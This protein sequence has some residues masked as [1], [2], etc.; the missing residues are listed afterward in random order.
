MATL[1]NIYVIGAQSTGKTTLVNA[2]ATHFEQH[3]E[4]IRNT[5]SQPKLI[6]EVARGVLQRHSY[7]ADDIVSSKSRALELQRLILEAQCEAEKA[8][9]KQWYISDRS[10][11]DP[12]VYARL[13]VG[14][15]ETS[16]LIQEPSWQYL[17]EMMRSGLVI[18]C[19]SGGEWLINDGVRLMPQDRDAWLQMHTTFCE[20]LDGF[21][22]QYHVLPAALRDLNGRVEFALTRWRRSHWHIRLLRSKLEGSRGRDQ[23]RRGGGDEGG[24]G[25]EPGPAG[26]E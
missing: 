15:D 21:G 11:L 9:S 6:K 13:F 24:E 22:I 1:R 17:Q 23:G 16:V 2:L 5:E 4:S 26:E 25:A 19:E 10:G 20:T 3:P 8:A 7:T 18:V 12:L 14:W